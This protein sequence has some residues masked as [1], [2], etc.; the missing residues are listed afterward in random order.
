MGPEP[1]PPFPRPL[2]RHRRRPIPRRYALGPL[3]PEL[4]SPGAR[5][6]SPVPA[7]L[8]RSSRQ[9]QPQLPRPTRQPQRPQSARQTSRP[10]PTAKRSVKSSPRSSIWRKSV[11][12]SAAQSCPW[13]GATSADLRPSICP[14]HAPAARSRRFKTRHPKNHDRLSGRARGRPPQTNQGTNPILI[15][16]SNSIRSMISPHLQLPNRKP[17][18]KTRAQTPPPPPVSRASPATISGVSSCTTLLKTTPKS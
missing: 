16:S 7:P 17:N 12:K 2:S 6:L 18:P 5:S 9:S 8:S 4:L 14:F 15:Y 11:P 1:A 10:G 3:P 13:P